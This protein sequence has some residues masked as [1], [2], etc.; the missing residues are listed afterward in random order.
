[1]AVIQPLLAGRRASAI[2]KVIGSSDR[3][4]AED[5]LP[6]LE[7]PNANYQKNLNLKWCTH[8]ELNLKPADPY[9]GANNSI[10]GLV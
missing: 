1:M 2:C 5:N 6:K 10:H 8:Q 7:E 3:I 9:K 4:L